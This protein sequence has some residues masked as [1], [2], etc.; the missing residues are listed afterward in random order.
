[1]QRTAASATSQSF[2][3][4]FPPLTSTQGDIEDEDGI[5][6]T[7][8]A[9]S[10]RRSSRARRAALAVARAAAAD[11]EDEIGSSLASRAFR[12]SQHSINSFVSANSYHSPHSGGDSESLGGDNISDIIDAAL[13]ETSAKLTLELLNQLSIDTAE[14]DPTVVEPEAETTSVTPT[15]ATVEGKG[16]AGGA[17]AAA[18]GQTA[19][20]DEAVTPTTH[21]T[22]PTSPTGAQPVAP[23]RRRKKRDESSSSLLE[24][25]AAHDHEPDAALAST[26]PASVDAA[27]VS[28]GPEEAPARRNGD[29]ATQGDGLGMPQYT[30]HVRVRHSDEVRAP[31]G[32][33]L[34]RRRAVLIP[35][36]HPTHPPPSLFFNS[37]PRK[38][39]NACA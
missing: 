3:L 24:N 12:G 37:N 2:F 16:S 36:A 4:S 33:D 8:S 26:A 19:L 10:R 6:R 38:S 1:V 22:G 31:R 39:L 29:G 9:S 7:L 35:Q 15:S 5:G 14:A 27:P 23:P 30:P 20:A 21:A 32:R 11:N 25:G 17:A 13:P 18:E 34:F 28:Q